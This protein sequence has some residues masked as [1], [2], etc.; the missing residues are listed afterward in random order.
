MCAV[1]GRPQH[2]AA[3]AV[4]RAAAAGAAAAVAR[5]RA[6]VRPARDGAPGGRRRG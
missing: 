6:L 4:G 3:R 5:P 2:A 1:R